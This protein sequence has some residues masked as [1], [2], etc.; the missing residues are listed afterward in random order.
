MPRKYIYYALLL[1]A[2]AWIWLSPSPQHTGLQPA[3]FASLTIHT[4]SGGLS[5]NA[6]LALTP[7]T[8]A[9]GLMHR[10]EMPDDAGM[11]FIF[12]KPYH[13]SMWMKDTLLPLDMF[14]IDSNGKIVHI[15][16]NAIPRSLEHIR[17]PVP[18]LAVLEMKGGTAAKHG[19][20]PGMRISGA[21]FVP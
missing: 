20:R 4:P 9:R 6:E 14:F 11:L 8:Q 16:E 1:V 10:S 18:A 2:L 21:G 15:A 7:E 12:E 5:V 3:Q 19:I 13:I 17:S